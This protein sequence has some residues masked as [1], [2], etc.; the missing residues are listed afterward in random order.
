MSPLIYWVSNFAI[1][2]FV[3]YL[4]IGLSLYIIYN[5]RPN[6]VDYTWIFLI[7]LPPSIILCS[8][9]SCFFFDKDTQGFV[10]HMIMH[11]LISANFPILPFVLRINYPGT[12]WYN[13]TTIIISIIPSGAVTC[14]LYSICFLPVYNIYERKFQDS[15]QPLDYSI[16]GIPL[17]MLIFDIFFYTAILIFQEA[18]MP[19][20]KQRMQQKIGK[21]KLL[22]E[23]QVK[24]KAILDIEDQVIKDTKNQMGIKT[25]ELSRTF[26]DEIAVNNL[27]FGVNYGEIMALLGV[28][29]A[30]KTTTFRMLMDVLASNSGSIHLY[31]N[32]ILST[33]FQSNKQMIGYCPQ[34][35]PLFE[36]LTVYEHLKFYSDVKGI[37]SIYTET[38]I[39]EMIKSM[40]LKDHRKKM[41]VTLSG[42]NKR[43]LA[44]S[45]ALLGNPPIL[46]MDE[47]STGIDPKARRQMWQIIR[48]ISMHRKQCGVL[49][50][51]HSME[52]AEN[53]GTVI[54]ILIKGGILKSY[55][56]PS[57]IKEK[58]GTG[59]IVEI[60]LTLLSNDDISNYL[61]GVNI[62]E[63]EKI[64]GEDLT[65]FLNKLSEPELINEI[66]ESGIGKFID[67]QIKS[68]NYASSQDIA[69]LTLSEKYLKGAFEAIK[70][71]FGHTDII[72]YHINYKKLRIERG[73][74]HIGKIFQCL[75]EIKNIYHIN[76]Y[77][78]IPTTLEEIFEI[79]ANVGREKGAVR[80]DD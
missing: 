24:E 12:I 31:G 17:I 41:A 57:Q 37:P 9:V 68:D 3:M 14:G 28:N 20:I 33:E 2:L 30:G 32:S 70:N 63:N 71:T 19:K 76:E 10:S 46:M 51:T 53:L 52:E 27:T 50:S 74:F 16:G 60:K 11:P 1:D 73:N 75:E 45:L 23:G 44:V 80:E 67:V 61:K 64:S 56:T 78:I 65:K 40:E 5:F 69:K 29:G 7:L 72:D 4:A 18:F 21:P 35:S 26:E 62:N 34:V 36:Y 42:G 55:G 58:Y 47:P 38:H 25:H 13:I 59:Y 39:E 49:L 6:P 15:F 22:M 66:D 48:S 8:Y 77:S 43:K 54:G 79:F